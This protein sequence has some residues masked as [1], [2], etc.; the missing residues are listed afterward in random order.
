MHRAACSMIIVVALLAGAC[1]RAER[2][3]D[4]LTVEGH[5]AHASGDTRCLGMTATEASTALRNPS[6]FRGDAPSSNCVVDPAVEG[7]GPTVDVTV[8]H[9]T[10]AFDVQSGQANAQ[11]VPGLGDRALWVPDGTIMGTLVVG[12]GDRTVSLL[13]SDVSGTTQDLRSRAEEFA[14]TVLSKM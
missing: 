13:I 4:T 3:A 12:K 14:R 2:K 7:S 8:S 10:G 11:Q 5:T 1:A 6:H 9:G